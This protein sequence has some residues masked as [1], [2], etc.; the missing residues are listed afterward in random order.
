MGCFKGY[1]GKGNLVDVPESAD[2]NTLGWT[3]GFP[4]SLLAPI[5]TVAA[6]AV[7]AA[8]VV[9]PVVAPSWGA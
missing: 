9:T 3:G 8:S 5:V 1:L 4:A 7:L 2:Y 6:V